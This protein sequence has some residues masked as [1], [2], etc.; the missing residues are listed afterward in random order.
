MHAISSSDVVDWTQSQVLPWHQSYTRCASSEWRV[1]SEIAKTPSTAC[2]LLLVSHW[3][4]ETVALSWGWQI[5]QMAIYT[6]LGVLGCIIWAAG[7]FSA[8]QAQKKNFT[9]WP[10]I[11]C[12]VLP[13]PSKAMVVLSIIIKNWV[14]FIQPFLTALVTSPQQ[15]QQVYRRNRTTFVCHT[16]HTNSSRGH[17]SLSLVC[18]WK[19]RP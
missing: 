8:L 2:G 7:S 14:H 5:Q 1:T 4:D 13:T 10:Q 18:T 6:L 11:L 19:D 3:K 12:G 15:I 9:L 17:K 16:W